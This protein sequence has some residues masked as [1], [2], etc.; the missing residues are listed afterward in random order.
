MR[1]PP[2]ESVPLLPSAPI[3]TVSAE[4]WAVV[5]LIVP[6]FP[7]FRMSTEPLSARIVS[8]GGAP[9]EPGS[10]VTLT[11]LLAAVARIVILP[12]GPGAAASRRERSWPV[13]VTLMATPVVLLCK[14]IF[15]PER[16]WRLGFPAAASADETVMGE[17]TEIVPPV[18]FRFTVPPAPL[19]SEELCTWPLVASIGE[20]TVIAPV[21]LTVNVPPPPAG[22]GPLGLLPSLK[23]TAP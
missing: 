8:G 17:L 11:R 6:K 22:P 21:A 10:P 9:A 23:V 14:L 20:L 15:P 12:P 16:L 3:F 18:E 2:M 1:P 13:L 4:I 7:V 19:G 5:R